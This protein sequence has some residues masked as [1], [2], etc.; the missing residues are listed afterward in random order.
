MSADRPTPDPEI[1]RMRRFAIKGATTVAGLSALG[2]MMGACDSG[3]ADSA[4]VVPTATPNE[5]QLRAEAAKPKAEDDGPS[6]APV[7]LV[8][9]LSLATMALIPLINH[10]RPNS[11]R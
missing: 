4:T 1:G 5:A 8:V 2:A 9:G 7:L 6:R 10:R 11:H 3:P